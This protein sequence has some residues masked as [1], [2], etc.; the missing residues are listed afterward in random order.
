MT[1]LPFMLEAVI[2][3]AVGGIISIALIWVGKYFVLDNV[4][5]GPTKNGVIPNLGINDVLV[6]G[7][8]GLI[9]GVVLSGITAF[10]TLRLYVRL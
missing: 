8:S 6:A 5:E 10:L 1:E 9:V 2:A 7:G 3:A 4:F